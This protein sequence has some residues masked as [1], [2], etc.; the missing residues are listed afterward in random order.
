MT[1][2][3]SPA[4]FSDNE[5][6]RLAAISEYALLDT[7]SEALFESLTALAAQICGTPMSLIVLLDR[8]RLWFRS[9]VGLD[10]LDDS[11]SDIA[12]CAQAV[13]ADEITEIADTKLDARFAQSPLV[14]GFPH[15]RFYA[16]V[17]LAVAGGVSLGTLCV[18]DRSPRKLN[19]E[20]H[21]SLRAIAKTIVN[22]FDMRRAQQRLFADSRAEVYEV[23]AFTY[24][25]RSVS[26]A[27]LRNLEYSVEEIRALSLSDVIPALTT[28]SDFSDR[29]ATLR[30]GADVGM[31]LRTDI[32]RR[33]G[34]TYPVDL[35]LTF[36]RSGDVERILCL[37]VDRSEEVAAHERVELLSA[38]VEA[39]HDGVVIVT[40]GQD[41]ADTG[42]IVDANEAYLRASGA[43][44]DIV[45][46]QSADIFD[47]PNS[48]GNAV[49]GLRRSL[50]N[51]EAPIGLPHMTYRTDGSQY[52]CETAG[53]ALTRADGVVT[54][55]VL[56]Q[57][58]LQDSVGRGSSIEL[59]NERLTTLTEVARNLF[60]SLD[61]RVLVDALIRGVAH[62]SPGST[63]QVLA[64]GTGDEFIQTRD[65]LSKADTAVANDDFVRAA[66]GHGA[67]LL[68]ADGRRAGVPILAPSGIVSY[69]LDI[70]AGQRDFAPTDAFALGLLGQYLAVAVR[71]VEL[72]A[73]LDSRRAAVLELN[74]VK[75]DLIAM[76]AHDFKGPLTTIVGLADVL[77][78]DE[79]FDA[80]SRLFLGMINSSAMRL[81]SLATDTLALS[82]LEQNE[83]S[84]R[85]DR[86][87]IVALLRDIV[88]VFS[89]TRGIEMRSVADAVIV[90]ADAVRLRQ[91]F[92][93]VIGNAI[94][95][96]PRGDMVDVTLR[97]KRHGVEVAVRDRGIGIPAGDLSKLFGRFA[98]G[99]NAREMGIG[100]TGFGLYVSR[101]IMEMHGGE[102]TIESKE[103]TGSTFR[104]FVPTVPAPQPTLD[105]R[106]VLLDAEE[107]G[108]SF[109]AH[110][111]RDEG[112]AVQFVANETELLA[113]LDDG[114]YDAA[115]VDIDRLTMSPEALVKRIA[116]RTTLVRLVSMVD[117]ESTVWDAALSKPFL[118]KDLQVVLEAAVAERRRSP[119]RSSQKGP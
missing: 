57:R 65:L 50:R 41:V 26:A 43:T 96:S 61:R 112:Y 95:Y 74:Q 13:L 39:V 113:A 82:R 52:A 47:G 9:N 18:L 73:E 119:R 33:S 25:F 19:A 62:L 76:L 6:R 30:S 48:D 114:R 21:A 28:A 91:V 54:H 87:D 10:G 69:V 118:I 79:R 66:A 23:D 42:T 104:V 15:I 36:S 20:Q 97:E 106:V 88:R 109:I 78:E 107:E 72:Y 85:F 16:G 53:R 58:E 3:F 24:R 83:L 80:E 17:P 105:R 8:D 60:G 5:E 64:R 71:N 90:R 98:R 63:A 99:S 81:A 11:A 55:L 75:N 68:S 45:I 27:A 51:G 22:Q 34:T 100:G 29:I 44:R 70:R 49:A 31:Q 4:P 67:V 14:Q 38:A 46:G 32:L 37:A 89:V 86:V 117:S 103:G 59:L 116:H 12:F 110:T 93:N 7:S 111:L 35:R 92:E 77:A 101:T 94:K 40:V 84:L 56:V 1:Q 2:T 115:I 108:R 102:I